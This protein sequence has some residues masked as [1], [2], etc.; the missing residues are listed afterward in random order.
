MSNRK[1]KKKYGDCK[2]CGKLNVLMA[3]SHIFSKGFFRNLPNY[4]NLESLRPN[5]E[6]LRRL[7]TAL[8]DKNIV[9]RDCEKDILAPLDNYG[10]RIFR[11]RANSKIVQIERTDQLRIIV[12]DEVDYRMLRAFLAS[13]L[14]R[15]SVSNLT[16]ISAINI[17]ED[18]ENRIATDLCADLADFKYID[19]VTAFYTNEIYNA[20]FMPW[21][22][23]IEVMAPQ[24]DKCNVNGWVIQMPKVRFTVSLDNNFHPQRMYLK[25]DSAVISEESD[26]SIHTSLTQHGSD[27]GSFAC[28]ESDWVFAGMFDQILNAAAS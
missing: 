19:S 9:C 26:L 3:D 21:T 25:F 14:W 2:L 23:T 12:F 11:D 13:V 16:E 10:I 6:H 1:H 4:A 5:G 24:R 8:H 28:F 17:G 18:W 22:K 7:P 15:C 27:S 20:F